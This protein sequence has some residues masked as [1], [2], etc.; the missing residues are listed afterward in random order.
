MSKCD[1][2]LDNNNISCGISDEPEV[3]H[4]KMTDMPADGNNATNWTMALDQQEKH[5]KQFSNHGKKMKKENIVLVTLELTY[6]VNSIV[7]ID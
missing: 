3:F 2:F 5:I 4:R 1:I 6:L 7:Q